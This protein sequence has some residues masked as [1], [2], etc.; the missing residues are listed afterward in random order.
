MVIQIIITAAIVG[1]AGY[2]LFK[3][4]KNKAKGKC[5]CSCCTHKCPSY[6]KDRV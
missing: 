1:F 3:N 2:M 4:L 5:D 6:K